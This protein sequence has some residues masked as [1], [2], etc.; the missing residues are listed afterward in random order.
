MFSLGETK[1]KSFDWRYASREPPSGIIIIIIIGVQEKQGQQTWDSLAVC[2]LHLHKE[3]V[4]LL[5][6]KLLHITSQH[7]F[8]M[9]LLG[10][11]GDQEWE[12]HE[13]CSQ[14]MAEF[15]RASPTACWRARGPNLIWKVSTAMHEPLGD[16]KVWKASAHLAQRQHQPEFFNSEKFERWK[17]VYASN[18]LG[19]TRDAVLWIAQSICEKISHSC[20]LC[21]FN[22]RYDLT[23]SESESRATFHLRS[24]RMWLFIF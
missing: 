14:T 15:D 23:G 5:Q 24:K 22:A 16:T 20:E 13:G 1:C 3:H 12:Q 6:Y 7:F 8:C 4:W 10:E 17:A 21:N 19:T 11:G 9:P 18:V 2:H